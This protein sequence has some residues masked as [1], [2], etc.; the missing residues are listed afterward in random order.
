LAE[1]IDVI[2]AGPDEDSRSLLAPLLAREP[3]EAA[4]RSRRVAHAVH[5]M[6]VAAC[7][8][9]LGTDFA[10]RVGL[11]RGFGDVYFRHL[12]RPTISALGQAH[13]LT[14]GAQGRAQR[15]GERYWSAVGGRQAPAT[16]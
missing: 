4:V 15:V 14:P 8:E 9:M 6:Y 10:D 12:V 3:F 13:Q 1:I 5:R 2:D 7:R 11:P 16:R